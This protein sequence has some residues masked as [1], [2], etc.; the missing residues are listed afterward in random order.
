[1]DVSGGEPVDPARAALHGLL[2]S[3]LAETPRLTG[4]AVDLDGRVEPGDLARE[5]AHGAGAPVVALR[6]RRRWLPEERPLPLYPS[7]GTGLRERGRYVITGGVGGLGLAV[8]RALA[9]TGLRPRIALLGRRASTVDPRILDELRALGAEVR[10]YA[11]DVTDEPAVD[12]TVADVSRRWGPVHGLFHLAGVAGDRMV[13]FRDPADAAAVLAPKT[14]GTQVLERAFAALPPLD[15]AVFFSSRAATEGLVGGGDYAAANAYLDGVALSSRLAGGRVLSIG[16]P[17]WRGAGMAA[18]SGVDMARIGESVRRRSAGRV[19]TGDGDGGPAAVTWERELRDATDWTLDEHRLGSV[20]LLPGTAM[21]DL[22][23]RAFRETVGCAAGAALELSDVV[24]R[25]PFL[26][27]A[28]RLVRI[29]FRPVDEGHDV[30]LA[31]RPTAGGGWSTHAVARISPA[32]PPVPAGMDLSGLRDRFDVAGVAEPEPAERSAFTLGPRW[33]NVAWRRSLGDEL[34]LRVELPAAYH[35]DLAEHILHPALL[36]TVTAAVRR[37]GEARSVPFHYRRLVVYAPLPARFYAHVRRAAEAL[38]GDLDLI[39]DDGSTVARADGFTMVMVEPDRLSASA[40]ANL[41]LA[42]PSGP[43][44]R[45]EPDDEVTGLDPD[46]GVDL[47]LRMLDAGTVGHVL[48]RPF[49]AGRPVPLGSD[50]PGTV[51]DPAP[52]E[53]RPT[54]RPAVSTPQGPLASGDRGDSLADVVGVLWRETL[55]LDTVEPDRDFFD[56]GGDSLSAVELT[57]RL[58]ETLG[59]EVGVGVMLQARTLDELVAFLHARVP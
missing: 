6:G 56:A 26:D 2:R 50:P 57:A 35:G 7:S 30:E 5:L 43:R 14:A 8:A 22:T 53:P 42:E 54:A 32:R 36:D 45:A 19:R 33:R 11:C 40:S 55:G 39:A 46:V 27:R 44:E 21:V 18:N 48:V 9:G 29:T 10:T 41:A 16:W 37:P 49:R 1:V 52:E 4:T 3:V 47:L 51:A 15:F 13:A 34:L 28:P 59:V 25:A 17:V 23:L 20:P 58:R 38:S 24:F 12:L 31:S